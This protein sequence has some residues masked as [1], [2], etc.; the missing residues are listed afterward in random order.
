LKHK[1]NLLLT[2]KNI[3]IEDQNTHIVDSITYAKR[4]QDAILTSTQYMDGALGEH[5]LFYK[6][7]DIVS[8]DFY[9]VYELEPDIVMVA[10]VD[11]TGH[12]VPGAFM[13]MIGNSLLNEI[14]IEN[15]RTQVE[16]VLDSM[17]SHVIKALKQDDE[18]Y[19]AMDGMDITLVKIDKKN[20]KLFFSSAGH[21]VYLLRDGQCMD[22][23]GDAFPVGSYYGEDKPFRLQEIDI[24]PGDT[25][26]LTTDG[27][28]DQFGGPNR[29]KFG[30]IN[31][32]ELISSNN[33]LSME[34]QKHNFLKAFQEW[35]GT[36][37]QID[38][39]CIMGIRLG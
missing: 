13:S 12:G 33:Y 20:K 21:R 31:F 26:Y 34:K 22:F 28:T 23:K 35:K 7:K 38:D 17:R 14:I 37:S 15:G 3:Q 1:A 27:Y 19:K 39:I 29:K 11:C 30:L 8:G 36:N 6:P 10:V 24:Q 5:F 16:K 2:S 9:W 32:K 25:L 18:K 4:I